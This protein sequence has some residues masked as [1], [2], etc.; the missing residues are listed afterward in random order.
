MK[1][2]D[3]IP[4]ELWRHTAT[5]LHPRDSAH[6]R[7]V[8]RHFAVDIPKSDLKKVYDC[9]KTI[10]RQATC[11]K[12]LRHGCWYTSNLLFITGMI[13]LLYFISKWLSNAENERLTTAD[14]LVAKAKLI[15]G[16]LTQNCSSLFPEISVT[17]AIRRFCRAPIVPKTDIQETCLNL[18]S[19]ICRLGFPSTFE[20]KLGY[21]DAIIL[22]LLIFDLCICWMGSSALMESRSFWDSPT[23]RLSNNLQADIQQIF[24]R[25]NIAFNNNLLI[26]QTLQKLEELANKLNPDEKNQLSEIK[27]EVEPANTEGLAV[28]LLRPG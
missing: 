26:E 1:N 18:A 8:A 5:F 2:I 23:T 20:E 17:D 19:E 25:H 12:A 11:S 7:Q 15:P 9:I 28:P 6:L 16:T 24:N 3:K 4:S 13:T 22:L 21:V 10:K 14:L 27:L